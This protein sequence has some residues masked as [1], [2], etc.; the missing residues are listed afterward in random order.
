MMRIVVLAPSAFAALAVACAAHAEGSFERQIAADPHGVVEIN[1]VAGRVDVTAWDRPQ[2][3]VQASLGSGVDHVDVISDHG[4]ILIK[5]VLPTFSAH[6][7]GADVRVQI[8]A[9]SELDVTTVSADVNSHGVQGVQ[10]LK[11]VSGAVHA[12]IAQSDIDAKTVSGDVVLRGAGRPAQLHL[13]T[14]SGDIRLD[15]GAGELEATSVSGTLTLSM[16]ETQSVRLR[17]TSG[18]QHFAGKLLKGANVDGES[19]SGDVKI[20]AAAELG[21]E[22]E[23]R[24]FSG[25]ISDCFHTEPERTSEY[26]PGK[27]LAGS[28]G[29]ASAHVRLKT[30]SGDIQLCDHT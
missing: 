28:R 20:N 25:D 16:D 23:A 27:R 18:D 15:H 19:V 30:M 2:V 3:S 7:G 11:T 4:H 8:P 9:G 12:D 29:Q 1:N 5:V 10:R 14:I 22:Y 24:S 6:S 26:G 17:T 13:T 21:F